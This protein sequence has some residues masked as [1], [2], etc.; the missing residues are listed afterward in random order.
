VSPGPITSY[1]G[2][3]E[4]LS[5]FAYT[6]FRFIPLP[7]K[8]WPTAEHCYQSLKA[9]HPEQMEWIASAPSPSE[10]KRRGRSVAM[11][12]NFDKIK[13][14][15]MMQVML[16]KF[17]SGELRDRLAATA[18]RP[19]V[20]GNTWGDQFWGAVHMDRGAIPPGMP[21]WAPAPEGDSRYLAGHNWLGTIQMM[22]RNL[23]V[24]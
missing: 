20:E 16:S 1:T 21:I 24:G 17:G 3:W 15:H 22:I 2:E 9:R 7:E 12:D 10:A 13:R 18:G 23:I 19:L 11:R 14:Q 6:P 5:N 4:W 8:V